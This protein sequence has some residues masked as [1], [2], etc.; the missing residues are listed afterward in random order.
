MIWRI[1]RKDL[2]SNIQTLRF[3]VGLALCAVLIPHGRVVRPR[4]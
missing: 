1:A 2:L 4:A 3:G